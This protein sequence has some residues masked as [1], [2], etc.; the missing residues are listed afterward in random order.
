ME[1]GP[2]SLVLPASRVGHPSCLQFDLELVQTPRVYQAQHTCEA[3]TKHQLPDLQHSTQCFDLSSQP[4]SR[5]PGTSPVLGSTQF[6][7]SCISTSDFT[8]PC[9]VLHPSPSS[10]DP[11]SAPTHSHRPCGC[12]AQVGPQQGGQGLS[13][14][15]G[16]R[17]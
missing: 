12:V 16:E 6:A 3:D 9:R 8:E 11:C 1:L 7:S 4:T 15:E 17:P 14:V 2:F 10:F 13:G 5:R